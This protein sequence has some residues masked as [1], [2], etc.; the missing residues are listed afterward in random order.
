MGFFSKVAE[1]AGKA[2]FGDWAGAVG[3]GLELVGGMQANQA[4]AKE[5]QRNREFQERLSS[6]SHQREVADLKA[7]GLNPILSATG[8]QGASTPAGSTARFEN[9]AKGFARNAKEAAFLSAQLEQTKSQT[10]AT[11]AQIPKTNAE[12]RNLTAD[13][14]N[15]TESN[16]LI[17]QNVDTAVAQMQMY[18]EQAALAQANAK[19]VNT[20]NQIDNLELNLLSNSEWAQY[21][22]MLGGPLGSALGGL[23]SAGRTLDPR[24]QPITIGN[25]RKGR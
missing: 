24:H 15:K 16:K 20:R 14:I 1:I 2:T 25:G 23:G 4:N 5:A 9:S 18:G 8:G 22:K 10:A 19:A 13:T 11:N 21:L 17:A 7:A 6:T 3:T 12:V